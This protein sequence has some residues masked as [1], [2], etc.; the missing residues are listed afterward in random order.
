MAD[1]SHQA[2]KDRAQHRRAIAAQAHQQRAA[3]MRRVA[4]RYT[5]GI[6][7]RDRSAL[8]DLAA[9]H[10]AEAARYSAAYARNLI[11]ETSR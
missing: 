9:W 10:D 5:L 7:D 6:T 3:L 2:A 1:R 8:V 11:E 4:G